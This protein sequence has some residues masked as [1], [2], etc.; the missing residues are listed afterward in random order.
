MHSFTC[1]KHKPKCPKRLFTLCLGGTPL[2]VR[3]LVCAIRMPSVANKGRAHGLRS[4]PDIRNSHNARVILSK[5]IAHAPLIRKETGA[6]YSVILSLSM[7]GGAT[8]QVRDSHSRSRHPEVAAKDLGW[9]DG[10]SSLR[11]AAALVRMTEVLF[12]SSS[13]MA[14]TATLCGRNWAPHSPS[15]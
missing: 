6:T 14:R 9:A 10:D 15:S 11:C 1:H 5:S 7:V 4:Q 13:S 2:A 12:L 3:L 8:L